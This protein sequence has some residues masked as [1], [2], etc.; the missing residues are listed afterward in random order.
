VAFPPNLTPPELGAG[1]AILKSF[2]TVSKRPLQL[3]PNSRVKRQKALS[4]G[5]DPGKVVPLVNSMF[6]FQS[7][8]PRLIVPGAVLA[9]AVALAGCGRLKETFQPPDSSPATPTVHLSDQQQGAFYQQQGIIGK[10]EY[11]R[12]VKIQDG[13]DKTQTVSDE[14]VTF[15][16]HQLSLRPAQNISKNAAQAQH[17][18]LHN[19]YA[20]PGHKPKHLTASQRSRLYNAIVP[21]TGSADQWVEV[22]ASLA[23]AGTHDPR[24]IPVLERMAQSSPY[25]VVR[26][27]AKT[28]L[29]AL[30]KVGIT[31]K[32][33]KEE[34]VP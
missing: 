17:L 14:D 22:D 7:T 23:L 4:T 1:G 20:S 5:I 27:D 2:Y 33:T 3:S 13:I 25:S 21:Y 30:R 34:S 28:W 12:L 18:V 29:E 31:A 26:L 6:S 15:I 10:Q 8:L 24:A 11:L 9:I 16:V 19:T 32:K